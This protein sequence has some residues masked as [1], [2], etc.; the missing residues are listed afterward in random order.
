MFI[1]V[2]VEFLK[3]QIFEPLKFNEL[4]NTRHPKCLTKEYGITMVSAKC[5]ISQ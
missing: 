5:A 4:T 1:P 2:I 3:K